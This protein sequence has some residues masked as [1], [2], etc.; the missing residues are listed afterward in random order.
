MK[1]NNL[2]EKQ[3]E[4]L[5]STMS[6]EEMVKQLDQYSE[7]DFFILD[8]D[9]RLPLYLDENL[10][11]EKLKGCSV[12]SIQMRDVTSRLSNQLQK[13]VLKHS[14]TKI[15]VLFTEEGLHSFQSRES[16]VFPQQIALASTFDP[17]L[18]YKQGRA[19]AK[20]AYFTGVRELLSPVM[21]LAR[22][23][24]YGRCEETYGEDVYLSKEFAKEV[25][26]GMQGEKLTDVFSV[27]S[28]PKH[29]VA[30]GN[31]IG[32]LN[33]APSTMGRRDAFAYCLPIFEAAIKEGGALN[34]MCSYNS[35]DGT[36]VAS[37]KELLTTMLRDNY[38]MPGF[39]RS[40]MTAIAML[41]T[42]HHIA[43]TDKEAIKT[44]FKAGV[45]MQ[46]YDFPHEEYQQTILELVKE[47][48]I[49]RAEFKEG[50]KRVLRVKFLLGLF[51]KPYVEETLEINKQ[52]Q[53]ELALEIARNSLILLKNDKALLPLDLSKY[54]N[55]AVLGPNSDKLQ[56]GD[57]VSAF[58]DS[59]SRTKGIYQ[60]LKDRIGDTITITQAKGCNILDSSI[61]AMKGNWYTTF[62]KEKGLEAEYF[63]NSDLSGTPVLR[64]IDKE[65]NFNWIFTAPSPCVD[66]RCFS[67]RWKA[68]LTPD[69]DFEGNIGFSSSDSMKLFIDGNCLLDNWDKDHKIVTVVPF[70]FEKDKSY[71][72]IV[73]Y[74]NDARGANVTLGYNHGPI[75]ENDAI[76][77][78]KN[79]D[80]IILALGE[81]DISCGEN[82]DRAEITLPGKQSELLN[83]IAKLGKEIVLILQN[84]R[85]LAITN[86][87]GKVNSIIEAFY[88]GEKGSE[89]IVDLLLGKIEPKGR[90]PISFPRSTGQIPCHYS[91]HP[92]GAM[93]YCDM[94]ANPLYPFGYGLSYT[95]FTY[96]DFVVQNPNPKFGEAV[97][98][99][100][101]IT[102]TGKREG[103]TVAQLYLRDE[104]SSVVKPTKELVAF[105][106]VFLEEGESK[107]LT[108]KIK[109]EAMRTFT[110]EFKWEYE[111]GIFELF[112]GQDSQDNSNLAT[113]YLHK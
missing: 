75:D 56:L 67:A 111:E 106:K 58:F 103:T 33:C 59:K 82:V 8:E 7:R 44:A 61:T 68:K 99:N 30:Y 5:I 86:E 57:Y 18:G 15:P 37:D 10:V 4:T 85:P 20:E 11:I 46:L 60:E 36:P 21:D 48:E 1:T 97:F 94:S 74:K 22:D 32:G 45:E 108:L 31:P 16:T 73:E 13:A 39:V 83:K 109:S 49:T 69:M 53:L 92:G 2:I 43:A 87:S 76:E 105:D 90:L 93:K 77:K 3:I 41:K 35:I 88:A 101:T 52:E 72:L 113:F 98:V 9:T 81:D 28:E 27:A 65:I 102:N 79:A 84:G 17:T 70:H 107:T 6:D 14:K 91:R 80:L 40:D 66:A 62:N 19:I 54:K 38:N 104:T 24:R 64:R 29:F 26:K 96:S 51:D 63:N 34:V 23:P 110:K 95:S 78:A 42:A 55:I 25:V 71:E 12:G 50:V 89:A 47:G 112:I 100:I